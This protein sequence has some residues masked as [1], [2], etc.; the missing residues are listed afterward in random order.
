VPRDEA[1]IADHLVVGA[2][3][4]AR[5]RQIVADENRICG[6]QSE[7]LHRPQMHLATAGDANFLTRQDES[8]ETQHAE[9]A[10][11]I[12]GAARIERRPGNWNQKIHRYAPDAEL[13]QREREVDHVVV[14][15]AHTDDATGAGLHSGARDVRDS[16]NAVVV[17]VRRHDLVVEP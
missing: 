17:G 11:G 12:E 5:R 10:A 8:V 6:V 7:R 13:A 14:A 2:R 1:G 3:S 9:A 15:L 4:L 16:F